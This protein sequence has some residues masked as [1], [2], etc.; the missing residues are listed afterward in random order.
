MKVSDLCITA[1]VEKIVTINNSVLF[2]LF[3]LTPALSLKG[4]GEDVPSP[5]WGEG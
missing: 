1:Q 4:E 5:L 2:L 3:T